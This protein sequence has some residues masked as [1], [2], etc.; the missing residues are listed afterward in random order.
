MSPLMKF[1]TSVFA[2]CAV[3]RAT[4]GNEDGGSNIEWWLHQALEMQPDN[5]R[6][7]PCIPHLLHR[8]AL[9]SLTTPPLPYPILFR[10]SQATRKEAEERKEFESQVISRLE[11]L[12]AGQE[13][14]QTAVMSPTTFSSSRSS[15]SRTRSSSCTRAR[16]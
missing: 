11:G 8:P 7:S 5:Y 1:V 13:K 6:W 3:L 14:T 10:S 9:L 16:R 2:F 12:K 15:A 4:T